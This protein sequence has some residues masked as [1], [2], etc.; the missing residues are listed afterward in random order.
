MDTSQIR[1]FDSLDID[2]LT[3]TPESDFRSF[4][5]EGVDAQ[6]DLSSG[7]GVVHLKL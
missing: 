3:F 1:V 2:Q 6:I 7:S 4:F 5:I